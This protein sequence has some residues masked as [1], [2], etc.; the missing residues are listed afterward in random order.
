MAKP[1]TLA[2][3]GTPVL[4][5]ATSRVGRGAPAGWAGVLPNG[6]REAKCSW[7]CSSTLNVGFQ[8]V[9]PFP[10]PDSG[11]KTGHTQRR[12]HRT[13]CLGVSVFLPGKWARFWFTSQAVFARAPC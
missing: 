4:F 3:Q 2:S 11:H 12:R 5:T 1:V 10:G 6:R 9:V 8:K 7:I 13:S